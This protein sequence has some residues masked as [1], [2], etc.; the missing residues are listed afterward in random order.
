MLKVLFFTPALLCSL[1]AIPTSASLFGGMGVNNK[2]WLSIGRKVRSPVAADAVA[3]GDARNLRARAA[4]MSRNVITQLAHDA[5]I[6]RAQLAH[7]SRTVR[8]HVGSGE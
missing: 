6:F 4:H 2:V 8:S 3:V 7:T 5:R 1:L